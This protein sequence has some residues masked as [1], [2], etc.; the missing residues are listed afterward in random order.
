MKK[1]YLLFLGLVLS[2][3]MFAQSKELTKMYNQLDTLENKVLELQREN[4]KA[5]LN[6]LEK[7]YWKNSTEATGCRLS[8]AGLFNGVD[9]SKALQYRNEICECYTGK[10][11]E[12]EAVKTQIK[13]LERRIELIKD[14]NKEGNKPKESSKPAQNVKK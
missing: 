8:Y 1:F 10:K 12:I 13:Q 4:D 6:C 5:I 9:W 3:A 2:T 7:E 11:H 14:G